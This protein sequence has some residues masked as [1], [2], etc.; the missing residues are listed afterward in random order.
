[1][2]TSCID[3]SIL[4][5]TEWSEECCSLASTLLHAEYPCLLRLEG[6][7]YFDDHIHISENDVLYVEE[8]FIKYAVRARRC[9]CDR[10]GY[11]TSISDEQDVFLPLGCTRPGVVK[12]LKLDFDEVTF[13]CPS[14][15]GINFPR[16]VLL[17]N[18][19]KLV[20]GQGKQKMTCV[21]HKGEILEV[22]CW[23]YMCDVEDPTKEG[24]ED[25]TD[26][27]E[28]HQY[29]IFNNWTNISEFSSFKD[30]RLVCSWNDKLIV[31]PSDAKIELQ[32]VMDE[33]SY[34]IKDILKRLQSPQGF[35]FVDEPDS[36]QFEETLYTGCYA[37]KELCPVI[38]MNGQ[39]IK[40][41]FKSDI[42]RFRLPLTTEDANLLTFSVGKVEHQSLTSTSLPD[43]KTEDGRKHVM[44]RSM[45]YTLI[46]H[47]GEMTR[48][49][50]K[51]LSSK[52]NMLRLNVGQ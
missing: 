24:G 34:F 18:D 27:S 23:E 10:R 16:F 13:H 42:Q 25:P 45:S 44:K 8:C 30:M 26:S 47:I 19:I 9:T 37:L 5:G 33:K 14:D 41:K 48:Q 7:E 32:G 36:G 46:Q 2:L 15:L 40:F 22:L 11:V 3:A 39:H 12:S 50:R 1:M 6:S 29:E 20:E 43:A 52:S 38:I 51:T 31:L 4:E 28:G 21:I 17:K 35:L 49:R